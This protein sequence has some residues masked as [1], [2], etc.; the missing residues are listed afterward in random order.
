MYGCE[1]HLLVSKW[2]W[3]CMPTRLGDF[4]TKWGYSLSVLFQATRPTYIHK[5]QEKRT[6]SSSRTNTQSRIKHTHTRARNTMTATQ[7]V[8]Q[9]NQ[10]FEQF[11]FKQSSHPRGL[12]PLDFYQELWRHNTGAAGRRWLRCD[13][14]SHFHTT[15]GRTD[16]HQATAHTIV[17]CGINVYVTLLNTA[18]L[19]TGRLVI[20]LARN[21]LVLTLTP[22]QCVAKAI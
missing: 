17:S 7:L 14:C 15:D 18:E 21:N 5:K 11:Q 1:R 4:A 10:Y 3:L 2:K 12:T 22:T 19:K 6:N 9:F 8:R 13:A 16:R 20:S